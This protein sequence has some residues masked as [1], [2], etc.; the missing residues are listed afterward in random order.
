M[1]EN[2]S[3]APS[4]ASWKVQEPMAI[5]DC[6]RTT[7]GSRPLDMMCICITMPRVDMSETVTIP[8]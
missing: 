1:V 6:L 8:R 4:S 2:L 7:L 3:L 5:T